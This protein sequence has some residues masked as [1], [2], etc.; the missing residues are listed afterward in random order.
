MSETEAAQSSDILKRIMSK[1]RD[2]HFSIETSKVPRENVDF[3][4]LLNIIVYGILC[5]EPKQ[6]QIYTHAR[7]N[8]RVNMVKI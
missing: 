2:I 1:N 5:V 4:C 7:D 6:R 3:S 8:E